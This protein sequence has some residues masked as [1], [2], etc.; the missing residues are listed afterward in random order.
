[1]GGIKRDARGRILKGSRSLN[2][3]GRPSEEPRRFTSDQL[4][5]D[6]LGLLDEPVTVIV[7]GTE[8]QMPAIIAIYRK[9]I[10]KAAGGDWPAINKTVELRDR[11]INQRTKV[12]EGLL[13][14]VLRLR[15]DWHGAEDTMP[16]GVQ[17]LIEHAERA[18]REGQFRPG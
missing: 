18:V 15:D 16:E 6:F 5:Q 1:M 3:L 4:T 13:S 11:Y 9:M 14:E 17:A 12:L 2:P 7:N 10:Q 8:K